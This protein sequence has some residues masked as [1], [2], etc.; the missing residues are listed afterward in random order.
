MSLVVTGATG[1]YGRLV[2]RSLLDRGVSADQ[3]VAGGRNLDKL[4]DLAERGVRT[5]RVDY[6]DPA[7]LNEA[8]KGAERVLIVS[9]TDIGKRV[10][11]HTAVARAAQ[12]AGAAVLY[13]SGPHADT[14]SIQLLG[15]HRETEASITALGVPFTVLRNGWYF[16]NY[17][18]QIPS[19][20][21]HGTVLGSA[22][23]GR[24][25]GAARADLAEAAAVVLTE[26]GHEGATY[27]LGGDS[28]SLSELA[29]SVSEHSGTPVVYTDLPVEEFAK[30]LEGAGLPAA[31]AAMLADTDRGIRAGDLLIETG[32]LARLIGRSPATLADAVVAALK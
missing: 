22:G 10:A 27:E 21:Q 32:D 9:G 14:S 15:E 29:A 25:S 18:A 5:A 31:I 17:T 24:I 12:E 28:F 8:V 30:A 1:S 2:V 16:E 23:D 3:I 13:T 19:Y 7:S 11:Q 20:L 6:D 26:D 4:A